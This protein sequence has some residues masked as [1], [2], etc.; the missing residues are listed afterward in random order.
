MDSHK[1]PHLLVITK[2]VAYTI[3]AGLRWDAI[4]SREDDLMQDSARRAL[5]SA[6]WRPG[7]KRGY[8]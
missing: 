6:N 4:K 8:P 2:A 3:G 1:N 7:R 5:S